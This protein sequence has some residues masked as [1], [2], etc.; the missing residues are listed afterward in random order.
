MTKFNWY[1]RPITSQLLK[2]QIN[3]DIDFDK[4]FDDAF[5]KYTTNS[6]LISIDSVHSGLLTE[7]VYSVNMDSKI[8]KQDFI[9]AIKA[10]N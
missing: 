10:I 8:K 1:A 4:L 3:N 7:L 5:L 2:I 6:E 9:N